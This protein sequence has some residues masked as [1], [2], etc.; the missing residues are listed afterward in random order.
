MLDV[1]RLQG[2]DAQL[3]QME[4]MVDDLDAR[5]AVQESATCHPQKKAAIEKTSIE[6]RA[7]SVPLI[8]AVSEEELEA[9]PKYLRGRLTAGR[10]NTVVDAINAALAEKYALLAKY[11][12]PAQQRS[13]LAADRQR[14]IEWRSG[15]S[16]AAD[17]LIS[18]TDLRA[19]LSRGLDP[20]TR[21]ILVVLRHAGRFREQRLLGGIT[22]FLMQAN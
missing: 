9:M 22:R 16:N 6:K 18:E 5:L 15:E 7:D 20:P 17:A 2:I 13:M 19:H 3:L 14:C 1:D 8:A 11:A 12:D 21:S 4:A 10:I